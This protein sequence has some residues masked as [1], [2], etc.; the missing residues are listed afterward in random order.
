[1]LRRDIRSL[2]PRSV[3]RSLDVARRISRNAVPVVRRIVARVN[4]SPILIL[5]NQKSGTTAI[6]ALL[7]EL[8]GLS[9]TLDLW[10]ESREPLLDR[11]WSGEVPFTQFV[12]ANKLDFSRKIIKEASLTPFYDRLVRHFPSARFV[13]IVRDPRDNIRSILNR[14]S[15]PGSLKQVTREDMGSITRAWSLV[16]DGR[17]LGID[18]D[19]YIEML[20]GRWDFFVEILIRNRDRFYLVRYEDFVEDKK[21]V[22][23]A[24]A[25]ALG[26][27]GRYDISEKVDFQFQPAGDRKVKWIDFFGEDNLSRINRICA[28]KM[29]A[30][31]YSHPSSV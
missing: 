11:V 7:A 2:V 22:M 24:V 30:L 3:K 27:R 6:A 14:L 5:G 25:D 26:L 28:E 29:E 20:A 10:R 1:M 13:F 31:G 16:L 4:R 9:A 8:T 12:R 19:N 21:S 17:W 15:I 18:G 23:G